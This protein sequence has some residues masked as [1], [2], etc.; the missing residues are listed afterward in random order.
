MHSSIPPEAGLS[1]RENECGSRED[2]VIAFP[3]GVRP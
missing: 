2:N 3:A 1:V